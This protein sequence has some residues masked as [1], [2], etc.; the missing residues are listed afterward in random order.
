MGAVFRHD[1]PIAARVIYKQLVRSA[2]SIGANYSEA[3]HARS[4][5]DF[6]SKLKICEAEAAE[7]RY[8]LELFI[9]S[10]LVPPPD[11]EALLVE[12]KMLTALFTKCAATVKK[13]S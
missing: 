3:C 7:S 11:T 13:I 2:T 10:D 9:E 5:A 6:V 1:S 8:W 4:T 12:A